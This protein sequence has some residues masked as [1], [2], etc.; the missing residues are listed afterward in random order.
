MGL[1]SLPML[2]KSGISMY[3]NNVWDSIKLYKKY[4]LGF[5]YLNDVIYFFLNENLYYYCIMKIRTISDDYRGIRGFKPIN[6]NK[7]KKVWN[8]RSFYLGK[9]LFLK[10]QGWIIVLIN[11]F[12]VRRNKVYYRYRKFKGFRKLVRSYRFNPFLQKFKIDNY[13]FKF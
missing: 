11:Y 10:N 5:F 12:T 4:N 8:M 9:I 13:K 2:N 1:K 6:I 7:L 3:W